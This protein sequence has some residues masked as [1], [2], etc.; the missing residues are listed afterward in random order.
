M[1][2]TIAV[3]GATGALGGLV[4]RQLA[5]VSPVL[6]VRDPARAPAIEGCEV[7]QAEY[8]DHESSLTALRG[9]DVLFMVS[10]HETQR[11]R[12]DHRRFVMAAADAG[13]RH[14]VYTSFVGAGDEATFTLARDHGYTEATIRGRALDFTFLRDN[15]YQDVLPYFFD[16][17]GVVRGP[18]GDGRFAPVSRRDVADVVTAVLREPVAHA[19]A[20]YTLTGPETLTMS[21]LAERLTPILG[22][23]LRFEDEAEEAAY[24]WRREKYGAEDWQLDAW[25]S[26][27]LAIRDGSM[28]DVTDDVERVSG[29]PARSLEQA[30][31][32]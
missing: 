23:K 24:T 19:G 20:A 6:V 22:R 27:Y 26:T 21:D 31:T 5:D 17:T 4:A 1:S 30:L 10:A 18:A 7:R 13:V 15:L 32:E 12:E 11:R 28:A 2:P 8:R 25:V 16:E 9:I 3:T 14:I 29:H